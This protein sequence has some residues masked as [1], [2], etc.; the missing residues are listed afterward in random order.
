MTLARGARQLVVQDALLKQPG[1]Q[2]NCEVSVRNTLLPLPYWGNA[3]RLGFVKSQD[4]DEKIHW[5]YFQT[6]GDAGGAAGG[7]PQAYSPEVVHF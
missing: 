4:G 2:G 6:E 3:H 7:S 1:M 5:G